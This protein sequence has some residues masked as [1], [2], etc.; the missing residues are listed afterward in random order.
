[1]RAYQQSG[2]MRA[3]FAYYRAFYESGLQ[4]QAAAAEKLTIPVLAIGGSASVG[5]MVADKMKRVAT[6]VTGAV[7]PESGHWIPEEQPEWLTARL[8]D[9]LGA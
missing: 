5:T 2:A 7:A 6:N 9:F 3:G 4:N 8:L 1:V